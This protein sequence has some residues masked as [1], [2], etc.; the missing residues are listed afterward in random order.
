MES[1]K[2]RQKDERATARDDYLLARSL[3]AQGRYDE[4][5]QAFLAAMEVFQDYPDIHHSLGVIAHLQADF[6]A[7]VAY[8]QKA[9]KLNPNYTEALLNLAITYNTVGLYES[10]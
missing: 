6:K 4:A 8:F 9:L 2:E 3:F 1:G 5:K 10:A 7:A